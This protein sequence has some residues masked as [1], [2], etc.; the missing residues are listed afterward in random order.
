MLD[1]AHYNTRETLGLLH[2]DVYIHICGDTCVRIWNCCVF[3]RDM[4]W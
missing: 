4:D 2:T 1:A 3:M